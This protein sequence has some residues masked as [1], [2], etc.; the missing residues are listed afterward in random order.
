MLDV[1]IEEIPSNF[2]RF[3][4]ITSP[5]FKIKDL[6]NK[7]MRMA[8][9]ERPSVYANISVPTSGRHFH[10]IDFIYP[11]ISGMQFRLGSR[12]KRNNL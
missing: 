12:N 6:V 4:L 9:L 8:S 10:S 1:M 7:T 5:D 11:R 2:S 3:Y